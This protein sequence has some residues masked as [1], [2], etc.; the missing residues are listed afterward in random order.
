MKILVFIHWDSSSPYLCME[1]ANLSNYLYPAPS[2]WNSN[3]SHQILCKGIMNIT[4]L[5]IIKYFKF[6]KEKYQLL[7]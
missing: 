2:L 5:I 3:E 6:S 7:S 4:Q 1:G